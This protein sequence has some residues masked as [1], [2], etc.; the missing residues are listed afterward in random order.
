MKKFDVT[1]LTK[2]ELENYRAERAKLRDE[3]FKNCEALAAEYKTNRRKLR[4][5]ALVASGK[6]PADFE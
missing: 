1:D 2:N 6:N 5:A 3:H 4:D